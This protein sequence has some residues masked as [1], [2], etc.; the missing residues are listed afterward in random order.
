MPI[1]DRRT[2]LAQW[3]ILYLSGYVDQTKRADQSELDDLHGDNIY[4]LL[5]L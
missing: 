2:R 3:I 1:I 4:S 5:Y